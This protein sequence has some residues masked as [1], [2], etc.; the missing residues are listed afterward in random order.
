MSDKYILVG[1]DVVPADDFQTWARDFEK[2]TDRHVA[3]TKLDGAEVS[4]VFL[5]LNHRFGDGPP[6]VFETMVFG[7]VCDQEQKRYST[8]AEAEAGHAAM[9]EKVRHALAASFSDAGSSNGK[10]AAFGAADGG[11][12]PSPAAT[13]D[14]AIDAEDQD[15]ID[16]E[17]ED[18]EKIP[19]DEIPY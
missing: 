8:W 6:L 12:T 16:R 18:F 14:Q 3:L 15:V 17:H 19:D 2:G 5:G 1:H 13:K 9:V 10:T 7:G 4:T 11:S